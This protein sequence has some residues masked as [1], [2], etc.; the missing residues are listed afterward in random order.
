MQ[1]EP[2]EDPATNLW[3]V[4]VLSLEAW[5]EMQ[6]RA[7]AVRMPSSKAQASRGKLGKLSKQAS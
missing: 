5:P 1:E 2:L 4:T 6:H 7:R 3:C